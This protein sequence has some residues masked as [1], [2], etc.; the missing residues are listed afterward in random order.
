[1]FS[2]KKHSIGSFLDGIEGTLSRNE[3]M[4]K[5]SRWNM[6]GTAQCYFSA[7]GK[8]SVVQLMCQLPGNIPITW[9]GS[10]NNTLVRDGGIKGVTLSTRVGLA[11]IR[12]LGDKRFYAEAGADNA[13]LARYMS[14]KGFEELEFLSLSSGTLGGALAMGAVEEDKWAS[15]KQLECVNRDGDLIWCEMSRVPQL[16]GCADPKK[17]AWI[18]GAEFEF[19]QQQTK[20]NKAL[21][22]F[23]NMP[24]RFT[25]K[26]T[27]TGIYHAS[28]QVNPASLLQECGLAG[29]ALG[30]AAFDR[31]SPNE[32]ALSNRSSVS[33]V[34]ALVGYGQRMVKQKFDVQLH[35]LINFVGERT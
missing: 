14:D 5:H 6:G 31:R 10:G 29:Y 28:S 19:K 20:R 26:S 24:S 21:L 25:G 15:I 4:G 30:G 32:L 1:M 3:P 7:S 33:D 11:V 22:L 17:Q 27:S 34:E 8:T 18:V 12:P 2:T 13:T 16:L 23:K 9:L 35:S